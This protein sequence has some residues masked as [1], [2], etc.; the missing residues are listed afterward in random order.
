MTTTK[1]L[2]ILMTGANSGI[3]EA[4]ARH[5]QESGHALTVV[6]RSRERAEQSLDWLQDP[7]QILIA[8]LADLIAVKKWL[9]SLV[10]MAS[11]LMFLF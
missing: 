2:R 4:A 1:P 3:G 6:C 9:I 11:S 8:D 10:S 7:S 5:L